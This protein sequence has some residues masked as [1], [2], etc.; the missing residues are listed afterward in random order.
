MTATTSDAGGFQ[1]LPD[2]APTA[3]CRIAGSD[4]L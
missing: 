1:V 2:Y 4:R 3:R